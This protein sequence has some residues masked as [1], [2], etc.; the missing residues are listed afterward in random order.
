MKTPKPTRK[1]HLNPCHWTALWN[2][3]FF[4]SFIRGEN[5]SDPRRR[6][7]FCINARSQNVY[8]KAVENIHIIEDFANAEVSKEELSRVKS[9]KSLIEGYDT[10]PD[11]QSLSESYIVNIE[12][13]ITGLEQLGGYKEIEEIVKTDRITDYQ[14]QL[15]AS[16]VIVHD[17]RGRRFFSILHQKFKNFPNP[18]LEAFIYIQYLLNEEKTLISEISDLLNYQWVLYSLPQYTF[19]LNDMPIIYHKEDYIWVPISPRHLIEI[20]KTTPKLRKIKYK[21]SLEEVKRKTILAETIFN[22][23][24]ELIFP[25]S[26]LLAK[27][28][29][30]HRWQ[31]RRRFL[32]ETPDSI[33]NRKDIL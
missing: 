30:S 13:Q 23:H 1:S 4:L 26:K 16:F 29:K 17:I 11:E 7:V 20:D 9:F 33:L 21:N 25:E 5:P 10:N 12:N 27:I 8:K 24:T 32:N 6:Q 28:L 19:P 18:R 3:E 31:Q 2:H 14:Q 15:A 22:T